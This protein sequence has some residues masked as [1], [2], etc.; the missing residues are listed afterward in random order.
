MREMLSST[1]AIVGLGLITYVA[2]ITDGRFSGATQGLCIGH[3]S[4]E[5][6]EGGTL[7]VVRD[8]D[9]IEINVPERRINVRLSDEEI[10]KRLKH[11][12]PLI[13]KVM[14]GYLA[15]YSRMVQSAD[16]GAIF[17]VQD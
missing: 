7:A 9:I 17:R 16:K 11:L 10:Q 5:A 2:L 4:P 8:G 1:S 14:K 15:R 13:P 6:A 12:K 3:L